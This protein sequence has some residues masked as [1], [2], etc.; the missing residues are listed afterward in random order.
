MSTACKTLSPLPTWLTIGFVGIAFVMLIITSYYSYQTVKLSSNKKRKKYENLP[1]TD[2]VNTL[3]ID[4]TMQEKEKQKQ[5]EQ[6]EEQEEED[7][8]NI[9]KTPKRRTRRR[10]SIQHP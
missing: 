1:K 10:R 4:D 3:E 5:E 9:L 8:S 2:A 6:K 7:R